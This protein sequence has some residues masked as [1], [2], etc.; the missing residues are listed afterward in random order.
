MRPEDRRATGGCR[1]KEGPVRSDL[2]AGKVLRSEMI[3]ERSFDL[4]GFALLKGDQSSREH[5]A[6]EVD[7]AQVGGAVARG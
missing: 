6:G 5:E 7:V 2:I 4:G 1:E 3:D